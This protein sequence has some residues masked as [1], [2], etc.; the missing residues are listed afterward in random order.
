MFE[1]AWPPQQPDPMEETPTFPE[2]A[3]H[4]QAEAKPEWS[5]NSRIVHEDQA[6][7]DDMGIQSTTQDISN[8]KA[9]RRRKNTGPGSPAIKNNRASK[10]G[11]APTLSEDVAIKQTVDLVKKLGTDKVRELCD[12]IDC[13]SE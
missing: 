4:E 6:E 8:V 7:A 5:L 13:V 3:T 2:A 11:S 1:M 10:A 12:V 9:Q